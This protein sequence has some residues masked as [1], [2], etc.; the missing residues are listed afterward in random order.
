MTRLPKLWALLTGQ[1]VITVA[2]QRAAEAKKRADAAY[3]RGDT[4][5][6][7][8]ALMELQQAQIERLELGQ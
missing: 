7:G 2:Q 8:R 1:P 4:R 5:G 6:Y 3:A